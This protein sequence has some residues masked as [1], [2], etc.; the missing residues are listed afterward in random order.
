MKNDS[1]EF[2][3]KTRIFTVCTNVN[4]D[5]NKIKYD[6]V[7]FIIIHFVK[8]GYSVLNGSTSI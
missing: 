3:H 5:V 4:K 8:I 2:K 1:H 6:C 7:I